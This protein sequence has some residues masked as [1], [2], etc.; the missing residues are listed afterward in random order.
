MEAEVIDR[1]DAWEP[2][3]KHNLRLREEVERLRGENKYL[4]EARG[5]LM[6]EDMKSDT[7][8]TTLR[9]ALEVIKN[10]YGQVCDG[11]ELCKHASCRASYS[12]W[13]TA[14]QALA[15]AEGK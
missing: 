13:A 14:D 12:A 10:Q 5:R 15:A 1:L 11:Y 4:R 9:E 8:I 2:L 3:W 6:D 7:T